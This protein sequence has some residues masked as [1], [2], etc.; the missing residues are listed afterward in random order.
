MAPSSR[1]DELALFVAVERRKALNRY[2]ESGRDDDQALGEALA[3]LEIQHWLDD[4]GRR[5][6][7]G[8]SG[9]AARNRPAVLNRI[10]NKRN[11]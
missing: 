5:V 6:Y 10:R 11:E 2:Y 9:E 1:W 4:H 3:Y 7:G 8:E